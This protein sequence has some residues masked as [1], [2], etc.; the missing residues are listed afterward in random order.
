MNY[1]MNSYTMIRFVLLLMISFSASLQPLSQKYWPRNF[2]AKEHCS[3]C[4]LC[5]TS[6]VKDVTNACPFLEKGM[7][8]IE[9]MENNIHKDSRERNEVEARFG[10]LYEP[11]QLATGA[12]IP[13]S[14][15]NQS[16]VQWTGV[17]TNLAITMLEL[18][19][20][21][22]VVCISSESEKSSMYPKPI[23]AKTV[24]EVLQGRGVKPSLAPSLNV[25][26]DIKNDPTIKKLLF[27]GVGCA[28]QA[29]RKV[30]DQLGLEEVYVIGTNC[31]DN[32]PTPQ[33][34]ENF[35]EKGLGIPMQGEGTSKTSVIGYEFMQDFRVHV[36][37]SDESAEVKYK[38]IPYFSLPGS[39]AKDSIAPSCLSCFDYTNALADISVGYMG[40]PLSPEGMM[41][42]MQ[43]ITIRNPKGKLV[44]DSAIE[45][46][47]IF[48]HGE[49][50][51]SGNFKDFVLST[52]EADTIVSGMMNSAT[53][54]ASMPRPL[55]NVLATIVSFI[56]PK[57]LNFAKY[58]ID[59]HLLRNYLYLVHTWGERRAQEMIPSFARNIVD[60]YMTNSTFRNILKKI[61][62]K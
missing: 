40:G 22:A 20:V 24:S 50:P 49:A 54:D 47:R 2:P 61:S 8:D 33:T 36:K 18:N 42:S 52:V 57:G 51:G 28:V 53:S 11:I 13:V 7:S 55:A 10:V 58:S 56:A 30:Q 44:I 45:K 15:Q 48:L 60:E 25:L 12:P 6:F 37:V 26:D 31:A 17:V 5:E 34:A 23:I 35:I 21:D 43:T 16:F 32:S 59:Y 41:S 9:L 27:C 19:M 38:K 4:G 14:S 29:F 1:L 62:S 39:I 3:K 46:G